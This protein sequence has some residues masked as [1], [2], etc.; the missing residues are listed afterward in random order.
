M[1]RHTG[2]AISEEAHIAQSIVDILSTRLGTRVMRRDYGSLIP[3]LIDQPQN[4]VTKLKLYAASAAAIMQWEP[5]IT[6]AMVRLDVDSLT[7]AATLEI[8]AKQNDTNAP[9]SI[10][11]PLQLGATR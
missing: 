7:G 1:N 2:E 9:F 4:A 6:L 11:T 10:R 5:R 8:E 3:E